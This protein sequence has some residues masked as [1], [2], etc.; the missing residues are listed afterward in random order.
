MIDHRTAASTRRP[1]AAV[2][3][4]APLVLHPRGGIVIVG[5]LLLMLGLM[6]T[7]LLVGWVGLPI[8]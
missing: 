5:L 7:P 8:G 6:L 3:A 4:D 1:V 2:Q